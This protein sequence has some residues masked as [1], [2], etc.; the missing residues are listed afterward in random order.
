MTNKL[1]NFKIL[2]KGAI[3]T[4]TAV[5]A[6][7]AGINKIQGWHNDSRYN[8]LTS[9]QQVVVDSL[10]RVGVDE[11]QIQH[12]I[13]LMSEV[14]SHLESVQ[15]AVD[16]QPEWDKNYD[17]SLRGVF[18]YKTT[19]DRRINFFKQELRWAEETLKEINT[20]VIDTS[21]I[22]ARLEQLKKALA[23]L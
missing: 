23:E 1:K 17:K 7:Y 14:I 21:E 20:K 4:A 15:K 11:R 12:E 16:N 3:I 10:K 2:L 5:L 9:K 6:I 19:R 18:E 8:K 13:Y 22:K